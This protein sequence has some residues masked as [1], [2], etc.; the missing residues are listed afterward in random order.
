MII[1]RPNAATDG[2]YIQW[3]IDDEGITTD[4]V[5][6]AL[7]KAKI[8]SSRTKYSIAQSRIEYGGRMVFYKEFKDSTKAMAFAKKLRHYIWTNHGSALPIPEAK[9]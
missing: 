3:V 8:I 2:W 9:E 1:P 7:R 5:V 6:A 4:E